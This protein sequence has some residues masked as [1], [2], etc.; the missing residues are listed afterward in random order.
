MFGMMPL[1]LFSGCGDLEPEMQDT[2][3]V[4]LKMNFN[5]RSSSRNSSV[6]QAEV[7]SHKTHLVLALPAWE[8]LSS[9]YRN[10]YSSFAQELM[11]PLDNKVSLEIPLNTQMKIFAFLFS[12]EYTKPQLLSGVREVGYYGQS[13]PFSIGTNTNNLRLN[14][15]LQ[16]ATTSDGE[17]DGEDSTEGGNQGGTDSTA[18]SIEQVTAIASPTNDSTPNYTFASTKA[19]TITYGG[20]CSSFITSAVSGNNTITFNTLSDGTY[21]DC[22]IKVTDYEGNVSNTLTIPA[23]TVQ[24]ISTLLAPDNFT[25]IGGS[26]T[27]T[28]DWNPVSGASSYNLYFDNVSGIDSSD[29]AITSISTDKYIHSGLVNDMTYFYKIA[30][31]DSLGDVS[32]LS[33][34]ISANT[35][36]W[37]L[38]ARQVDND[39]NF[40]TIFST[41]NKSNFLENYDDPSNSTFMSIGIQEKNNYADSAGNYK[42]KLEWGGLQIEENPPINKEVI[43]TQTSWLENSTITG[44]AEISDSGYSTTSIN[45]LARF[46]GLG[47]SSSSQCF[48]DGNGS[49]NWW[50]NCVG[51]NNTHTQNGATGIPGPLL[52]VASSMKLY[53]WS[54]IWSGT[55][56]LGTSSADYGQGV[57]VDSAGNIYVTGYTGNPYST[58][59]G[60]DGNTSEGNNDI[61]LVKYNSSGTKQ[62]TKQ[63]GTSLQDV[64][65]GVIADSAGNIYVTG[66]TKGG[67]DG[68]TSEGNSDIFLVKYN[69]SGTKQWTKQLGTSNDDVAN[70]V[71][72]D[73]SGN[74]YV[75][76]DTR[77][78]LDGNTFMGGN[79]YGGDIFLVKYNSSGTKQWTKQLGTS[80]NEFGWGVTADSADN[81]YV[82]GGTYSTYGGAGLDGNTSEGNYDIFLVKY[83]SSGTKQWTKQ[84][85]TS[86]ADYGQGVAV[87]SAGNIY[88]TGYTSGGLDGNT[89]EGIHDIF[90]VKYYSSGVKQ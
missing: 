65:Q 25:A 73:S 68:N 87:D 66:F 31:V 41:D 67:L 2:R 48:I 37:Q 71:A 78:G 10:Y 45:E 14:I 51:A 3:T 43:W 38:I 29:N 19:G 75:T 90:L 46:K 84:L 44:F 42:F 54:N 13:Q 82:T 39:N 21:S 55:K 76:G 62:W 63:L 30:A 18:P 50:W 85:G 64:G 34:E 70:G 28:L 8:D 36:F 59:A 7:S 12:E 33:S 17:D 53:I 57:A 56:Q 23:F 11:N 81:I 86:S 35:S 49:T 52:R 89:N 47:A 5:Q 24:T 26:N 83:N 88:I 74:V 4:V 27:I 60:L 77:G 58:S 69:S 9:N 16:S 79:I 80:S 1:F 32:S 20:P 6:S 40:D 15:T 22:T 61:F 72:T